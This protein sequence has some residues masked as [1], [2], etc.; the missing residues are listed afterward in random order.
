M[1]VGVLDLQG[2]VIEH[3]R[4]LE[5]AGAEVVR[6]KRPRHLEG[7][8]GL[9]IPGGESTTIG[10]LMEEAGLITAIRDRVLQEQFPVYGTCAG[11][12]VLAQQVQGKE[13]PRLNLL[14]VTV[15]RNAWGRQVASFEVELPI[16]A[17]GSDPFPAVFIR[18]PRILQVGAGVN[19]LA[20]YCEEPVAVEAGPLLGTA[21]HPELTGDLRLH[22]YFVQKVEQYASQAAGR[23]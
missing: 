2:D 23:R 22:R 6:V 3:V 21:F 15:G 17:L 5:A 16:K 7:L 1:K 20:T 14:N 19:V 10:M 4:A 11:L 18:A 12:I 8:R 9:V 13:A